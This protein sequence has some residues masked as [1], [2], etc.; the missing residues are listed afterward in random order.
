MHEGVHRG[1]WPPAQNSWGFAMSS[2]TPDPAKK[3]RQSF[4]PAGRPKSADPRSIRT[5]LRLTPAEHAA[6][7]GAA[8]SAG[9]TVTRLLVDS[10]MARVTALSASSQIEASIREQGRKLNE[11]VRRAN[12]SAPRSG[13]ITMAGVHLRS[14]INA[15][16][17]V[18]VTA[19]I[20][21]ALTDVAN[22]VRQWQRH[23]PGHEPSEAEALIACTER[24]I[25]GA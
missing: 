25:A 11:I 19:P 9:T 20:I 13:D 15:I 16:D 7:K 23:H 8:A 6:L 5:M 22:L 21:A 24:V 14:I 4:N 3:N 10:A 17:G 12:S 1:H 2:P 18:V